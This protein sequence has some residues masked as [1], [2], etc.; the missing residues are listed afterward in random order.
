MPHLGEK[1]KDYKNERNWTQQQMAEYLE[2]GY[3]TYQDIEKTGIIK[4]ADVLTRVLEKTHIS[5]E[6]ISKQDTQKIAHSSGDYLTSRRNFKIMDQPYLVPL[7]P[8]KAQ[9]GYVR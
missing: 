5:L 8:F 1:L 6:D 9:A 3:R 4:K 2:I 7:V